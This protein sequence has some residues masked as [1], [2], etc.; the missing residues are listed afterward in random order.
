MQIELTEEETETLRE[1][2]HAYLPEIR[3]E[4]ARTDD[5]EMRHA[6]VQRQDLCERLVEQ[7]D[8]AAR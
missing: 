7:L 2:L 8:A 1:M 3:R 5:R 4:A 6:M